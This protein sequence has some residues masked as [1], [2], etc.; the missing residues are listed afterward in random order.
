MK[1]ER[2]NTFEGVMVRAYYS[3]DRALFK[4]CSGDDSVAEKDMGI[5]EGLLFMHG[6]TSIETVTGASVLELNKPLAK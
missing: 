6:V 5:V 3:T 2:F 4:H 1:I